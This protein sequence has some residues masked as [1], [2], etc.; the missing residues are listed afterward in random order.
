METTLVYQL[1][2]SC[3]LRAGCIFEQYERYHDCLLI[4][5][6]E[7]EMHDIF[8]K[9]SLTYA[10]FIQRVTERAALHNL[11][12]VVDIAIVY[13]RRHQSIGQKGAMLKRIA[14]WMDHNEHL[15]LRVIRAAV[16]K[17]CIDRDVKQLE[18][19]LLRADCQLDRMKVLLR[20]AQHILLHA[21]SRSQ[22]ALQ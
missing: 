9:I 20:N 6:L 13:E 18:H 5:S 19:S 3:V 11:A 4:E 8:I 10:N 2:R 15:I 22:M 12:D 21:G 16:D 17:S 1:Y 7:N 14:D